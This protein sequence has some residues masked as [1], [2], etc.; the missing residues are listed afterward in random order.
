MTAFAVD[1][2]R[3]LIPRWRFTDQSYATEFASDPRIRRHL[4]FSNIHLEEKLADWQLSKSI[5]TA[6]DVVS[7][8]VGGD[9]LTE[10]LPAAKYL[11]SQ[12]IN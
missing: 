10:V 3:R 9:W 7:C 6:I 1:A 2:I 4:E 12:E 11:A 5:G 8:G